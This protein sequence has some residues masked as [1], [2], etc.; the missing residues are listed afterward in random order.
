[1]DAFVIITKLKETA[2]IFFSDRCNNIAMA[3]LL[4]RFGLKES[5]GYYKI[6][7]ILAVETS[8]DDTCIAIAKGGKT[9]LN[10]KILSSVVSSQVKIHQKFGGVYPSLARREHEKNLPF[11]LKE[12]LKECGLLATKKNAIPKKEIVL[13]KKIFAKEQN[14]L[15]GFLNFVGQYKK[16]KI[17]LLAVTVGPGLEPCLWTG[18]NFAKALSL[19]LGVKIVP[20]NHI[21]AHVFSN[22]LSSDA[23]RLAVKQKNVLFPSIALIV[24][25]GH[26]QLILVKELGKYKIL[27]ETRDDAA[28]EAFDKIAR[29]LGLPYPGGPAIEKISKYRNVEMSKCRIKLPRPMIFSK[30]YDFSFSGLKTAVLYDYKKRPKKIRESKG[31]IVQMAREAQEAI[32]E[33]LVK[34]TIRA[35]KEFK[36]KSIILGGGVSA[37]ERLRTLFKEK[38]NKM[39][40]KP[41]LLFP[42]KHLATD[43]AQMVALCGYFYW[44]KSDKI[45]NWKNIKACAGLRIA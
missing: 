21:E 18:V 28:G 7:K 13:Y 11:V 38:I 36:A 26:T 41:L 15:K 29:I 8:C 33:V 44:L 32:V 22:F 24:S 42:E 20:V 35:T 45:K 12:S 39:A 31:Y 19:W 27:G 16:P 37:N 4:Q 9:F 40:A 5:L 23:R 34:K 17:D 3:I 6:M 43:N 1:M 25:G 10:F 2:K 30:D 14:L